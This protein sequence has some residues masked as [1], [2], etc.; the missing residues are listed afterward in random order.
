M[1]FIALS[2]LDTSIS[3]FL[4]R[5]L[6]RH[7]LFPDIG[8]LLVIHGKVGYRRPAADLQVS[9]LPGVQLRNLHL[10]SRGGGYQLVLMMRVRVM[11]HQSDVHLAEPPIR[12]DLTIV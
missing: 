10:Q 6:T 4:Y 8:K 2:Y 3:Y 1:V 11:I 7:R 5:I 12:N 9:I